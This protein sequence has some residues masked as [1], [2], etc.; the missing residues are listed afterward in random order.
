MS[1]NGET[2][3]GGAF[4]YASR[5]IEDCLFIC[6]KT[7]SEHDDDND[8]GEGS[9]KQANKHTCLFWE[10]AAAIIL[11]ISGLLFVSSFS[12]FPFL[13]CC[14]LCPIGFDMPLRL[15]YSHA[16]AP[17]SSFSN[18][19]VQLVCRLGSLQVLHIKFPCTCIYLLD[20]SP[21]FFRVFSI[22]TKALI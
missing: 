4:R 12:I 14:F 13:F 6:Y 22:Y 20:A 17:T 8:P 16:Y 7:I 19:Y 21:L 9:T 1:Q 10:G 11:S 3:R 15:A 2:R 18:N 5:E